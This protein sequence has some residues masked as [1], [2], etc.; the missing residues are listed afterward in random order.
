M[1]KVIYHDVNQGKG[2]TLR[3]GLQATT[4]DIVVVQDADLEYIPREYP[5]LMEPIVEGNAD[6]VFG[7]RIMGGNPHRVIYFWHMGATGF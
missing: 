4:G 5:R 6:V 2:A 1:D 7:S 3:S